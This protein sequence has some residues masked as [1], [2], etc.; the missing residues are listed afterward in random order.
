MVVTVRAM[1]WHGG[2]DADLLDEPDV[3]AVARGT[4]NLRHHVERLVGRG[5][6]VVV[7][8]NL[9]G[10]EEDGE[11]DEVARAARTAGAATTVSHHAFQDG[12][13]GA[14]DLADAV[15]DVEPGHFTPLVGPDVDVRAGLERRARQWY[16]AGA[17]AWSPE[18][19]ATLDWLDHH[20]YGRLPVCVAK[21]HQ[22]TSHDPTLRGAPRGFTFP[23]RELRLAAGAGY[24]T[25]LAGD[26][27][28]MP[29]LPEHPRYLDVDLDED[30]EVVGLV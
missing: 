11:L 27:L 7:A 12:G 14:L 28:T 25:A 16:G 1:R 5:V 26:V 8:I 3:G 18:A 22:S 13:K 20:G 29:G 15:L 6:P 10:G 17:V 19:E 4:V 21:A 24:V 30:G 2:V 9:H 23:V